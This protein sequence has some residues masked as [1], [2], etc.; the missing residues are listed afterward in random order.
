[1]GSVALVAGGSGLVGG[2]LM[3]ELLV[4]PGWDKVI[5]VGRRRLGWRNAHF[6]E[7]VVEF[8]KLDGAPV[9]PRADAAFCCLGT[10][11]KKAGGREQF[12]AVDHGLVL[13][14]AR[15][16]RASGVRRFYVV[17]AR[18][19]NPKSTVFYNRV[20]GDIEADLRTVGFAALGIARPSL[21]L[22]ERAETRTGETVAAFV[23][24]M[25][26]PLV[27]LWPARP[28]EA[29]FVARALVTMAESDMDGVRV[30]ENTALFDLGRRRAP[31]GSTPAP[32][33]AA[34]FEQS[35][36]T[37]PKGVSATRR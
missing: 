9:L 15:A 27:K 31:I 20:K 28:I 4:R 3:G 11:M 26:G 24:G 19:A 23:A 36:S 1:M 7:L 14:F 10:T 13:R 22:G 25:L 2:A 16:A 37:P 35:V 8:D 33:R 34:Y 17:T 29:P 30:A 6:E 21:L 5:S 32:V 12:R 18:G